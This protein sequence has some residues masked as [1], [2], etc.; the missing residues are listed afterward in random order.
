MVSETDGAG[1]FDRVSIAACGLYVALSIFFFGRALIYHLGDSY[2]GRNTDPSFFIW[3]IAWWPHAISHGLNPIFSNVIFAPVGANLVWTTMIPLAIILVWP[4]T[5][6]FGPMVS[7]NLL[8]LLLPALSAWTT[9][10]LCRHL[11]KS[12]WPST[13]AGYVFGFSSYVLAQSLG[14]HL[15]LVM[16]FPM[17]IALYLAAKWFEG[18][19]SSGRMAFLM[20]VTLAVQFLL[21]VEIYATATMFAGFALLLAIGSTSGETRG[22]VVRMIGV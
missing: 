10:I 11:T 15:V 22:R 20:G 7:Y 2:V 1:V 21:A 8:A 19:I 18:G 14:G 3:S 5:A 12:V 17:P 16:L 6:V 13:L 4:I 9:F